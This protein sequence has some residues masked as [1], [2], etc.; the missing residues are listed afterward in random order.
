MRPGSLPLLILLAAAACGGGGS[1]DFPDG[2][3]I[4]LKRPPDPKSA[5]ETAPG[6][7]GITTRGTC[8]VGG[9][10]TYCD[11]QLNQKVRVECGA[12]TPPKG[13]V[14]DAGRG[15]ICSEAVDPVATGGACGNGTNTAGSCDG[16]TAVWCDEESG[17]TQT[18]DC[19]TVAGFSCQT[20]CTGIEGAYCC[21][22]TGKSDLSDTCGE[23][24]ERGSCEG[25]VATWCDGLGLHQEDCAANGDACQVDACADGAYCCPTCEGLGTA[26]RCDGNQVSY[27]FEG[28]VF[29]YE[30]HGNQTCQVGTCFADGAE[31]CDPEDA[32]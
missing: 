17:T 12:L 20:T 3:P 22:G 4:K 27:C 29:Q 5:S 13:C 32:P 26:G 6:C 19:S 14:I 15:A 28:E 25:Q 24:T 9:I 2:N 18:W 7:E 8:E 1:S 10:A 11:L 30:C 16:T 21:D 31:C 23:V